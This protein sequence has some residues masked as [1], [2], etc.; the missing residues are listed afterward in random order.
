MRKIDFRVIPFLCILYLLAFLD[1]VNI[2]NARSFGLVKDLNL[3]NLEFNTAL[4]IFF[5]PYVVFEIPSNILL[6]KLRPNVWLS[7]CMFLFG[8]VSICQGLVQNYSGLLATRFFLG[9]CETGMFPGCF[10]LIGM[11]YKRSEA[12]RRYSFFFSSTTLAGALYVSITQHTS[13]VLTLSKAVAF[14]H[15]QLGRWTGFEAIMA[16]AGSSSSRAS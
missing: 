5:V 15:P 3:G 7:G 8:V 2:A 6:K 9:I 14:L 1:R 4:T 10:Y 12:Q 11:W 13:I 16:G